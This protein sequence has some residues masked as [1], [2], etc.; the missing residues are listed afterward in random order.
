VRCQA[1]KPRC[2]RHPTA[3]STIVRQPT[4][5][6]GRPLLQSS[7]RIGYF[8]PLNI[9]SGL[10][11]LRPVEKP[12]EISY[13]EISVS[14]A[15]PRIKKTTKVIT[16]LADPYVKNLLEHI[17]EGKRVWNP[18]KG[19]K[20]FSQGD[21][22]DAIFYVQSGRVK[23]T[24]MSAAGK[25]AVIAVVGAHSFLGE[26]ALV[27]Q[28]LRISTATVLAPSCIFRVEKPS[29]LRAL[30]EQVELSEKFIAALLVRNIALEDDL[31]D[32]LF[33]HSEKR[34]AH[35]LLKLARLRDHDVA[36]DSRI[37]LLSH[38]TLAEMVGTTRSRITHF[39]NKFRTLGLI[40]YNGELTVRT[41]LLTDI[42]LHD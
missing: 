18:Q 17:S 37:P 9:E 21:Q 27:G 39:M 40:D 11:P 20:I 34:L 42:V 41:E 5:S 19:E 23:I 28:P 4:K 10:E 32:Q 1:V 13:S 33:N 31:C 3:S 12:G 6:A 26:G 22:A 36:A 14:L 35:V 25:E 38:E 16:G 24:V 8:S 15:V 7:R 30:H 2:T 29:M